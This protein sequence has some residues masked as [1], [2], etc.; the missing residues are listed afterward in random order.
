MTRYI[1]NKTKPVV[2]VAA[3]TTNQQYTYLAQLPS[4][5]TGQR[6]TF[7]IVTT[8]FNTVSEKQQYRYKVPEIEAKWSKTS[9]L[10][11]FDYIRL[12]CP[13]TILSKFNTLTET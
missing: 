11:T 2:R 1:R 8:D 4:I 13:V 3:I 10:N 5:L 9:N 6:V 7:E 12:V